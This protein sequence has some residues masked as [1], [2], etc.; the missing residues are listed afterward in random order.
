MQDFYIRKL[1]KSNYKITPRRVAIIELFLNQK[2][3]LDPVSIWKSLK[4][5][6]KH[7]GL[8]GVYRNLEQMYECGVLTKI[9]KF[10]RKRY[11]GLCNQDKESHHHHIV[12]IQCGKIGE[13]STCDLFKKKT[14]NGYKIINHFLQLEGVCPA[15]RKV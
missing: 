2:T 8:P 15:C 4:K 13:Y 12:C 5:Q 11:Y 9:Q 1:K 7:C 14:I 6:F 10:D 3:F